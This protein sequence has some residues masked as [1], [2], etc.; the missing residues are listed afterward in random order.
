MIRSKKLR[1]SARGEECTLNI[2]GFC[3]YDTETTVLAHLP[4]E[5]HGM[6]LKCHDICGCFACDTCHAIID[7]RHTAKL[8]QVD[9]EFYARRAMVRTYSR[10]FD[11]GLLSI[12]GG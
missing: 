5:S 6:G 9:F 11:M 10:W 8:S 7:G 2:A 3:R 4:H 12:K 1:D